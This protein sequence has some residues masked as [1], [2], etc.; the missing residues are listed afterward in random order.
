MK[1]ITALVFLTILLTTVIGASTAFSQST[2]TLSVCNELLAMPTR[3]GL[4]PI[5]I[6]PKPI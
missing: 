3:R 1:P 4:R 6:W 2:A 5:T